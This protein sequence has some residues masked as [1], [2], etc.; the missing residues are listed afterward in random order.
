MDLMD[1]LA[2]VVDVVA[3][4]PSGEVIAQRLTEAGFDA[5]EVAEAMLGFARRYTAATPRVPV[6]LE[7][8]LMLLTGLL[9]GGRLARAEA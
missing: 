9:V 3:G 4:D 6:E 7:F 5:G 8:A 2:N 1:E